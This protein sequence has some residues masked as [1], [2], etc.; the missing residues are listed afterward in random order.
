MPTMIS[1]ATARFL[2]T[3]DVRQLIATMREFRSRLLSSEERGSKIRADWAPDLDAE[4]DRRG[5]V[6]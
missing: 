2:P 4:D 3:M 6:G 5:I 1:S